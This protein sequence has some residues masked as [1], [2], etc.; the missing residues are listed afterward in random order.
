MVVMVHS[1]GCDSGHAVAAIGRHR[2]EA[3]YGAAGVTWR[4][5]TPDEIAAAEAENARIA[6]KYGPKGD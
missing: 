6:A 1:S 4:P 5:A 3:Q 2:D